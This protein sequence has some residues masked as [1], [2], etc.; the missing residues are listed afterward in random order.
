ME[1]E[2]IML[3]KVSQAQKVKGLMFSAS[4]FTSVLILV[5]YSTVER[6]YVHIRK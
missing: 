4:T 1:L 6:R 5:L 3:N 2:I